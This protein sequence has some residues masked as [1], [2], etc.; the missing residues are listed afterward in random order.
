[1]LKDVARWFS[2]EGDCNA[3]VL[4]LLG[5]SLE[6]LFN[7]YNRKLLLKTTLMLVDHLIRRIEYIHRKS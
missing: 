3:M 1:M 4:K 6:D 5:P 2:I 7:Y